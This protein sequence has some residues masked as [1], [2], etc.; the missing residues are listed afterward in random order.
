MRLLADA[1]QRQRAIENKQ[2]QQLSLQKLLKS[3][4]QAVST[5]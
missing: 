3:Q 5:I 1:D 2:F 4:R